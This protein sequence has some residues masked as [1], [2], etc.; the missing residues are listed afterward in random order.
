MKKALV[1]KLLTKFDSETG[2]LANLWRL[3][4]SNTKMFLLLSQNNYCSSFE[5]VT[6]KIY[7]L[8]HHSLLTNMAWLKIR[9]G[10]EKKSCTFVLPNSYTCI[11]KVFRQNYLN[12]VDSNEANISSI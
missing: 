10:K 8:Q 5:A 11:H 6:G 4:L 9:L 7:C 12:E 3:Q 2:K 1:C